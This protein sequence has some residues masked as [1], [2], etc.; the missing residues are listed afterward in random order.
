MIASENFHDYLQKNLRK[1]QRQQNR[2]CANETSRIYIQFYPDQFDLWHSLI[3]ML[4]MNAPINSWFSSHFSLSLPYHF[5]IYFR[6]DFDQWRWFMDASSW[7]M[8]YVTMWTYL[9]L[10][11]V[12]HLA[13]LS[14][15]S[16]FSSKI[17]KIILSNMYMLHPVQSISTNRFV[18]IAFH[19]NFRFD[20]P[21]SVAPTPT[22]QLTYN[23]LTSVN[24]WLLLF[25]CDLC[26][27]WTMGTVP[28]VETIFDTRNL[29][30]IAT[31]SLF[32]A[33]LW[34]AFNT[35]NQQKSTI[36]L[37][38]SINLKHRHLEYPEKKGKKKIESN[39]I[40]HFVAF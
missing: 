15:L 14:F 10:F 20:N 34:V 37:M 2:I 30:T 19:L 7:R 4:K 33:L 17:K 16:L 5:L 28:L 25:P 32:I 39:K 1:I 38:V 13:S 35:D 6:F 26:C 36:I 24:F 27:D 29:A 8:L 21:A 18:C 9:P 22:R 12:I 40:Y 23:Y 11:I 31:Y 3:T